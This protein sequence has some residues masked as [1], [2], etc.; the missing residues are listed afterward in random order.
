MTKHKCEYCGKTFSNI[1]SLAK[2]KKTATYCI[3]IQKKQFNLEPRIESYVCEDCSQEFIVKCNY[4]AHL[5][6]C[7]AKK[8]HKYLVE[9]ES[10]QGEVNR[11][12]DINANYTTELSVYKKEVELVKKMCE[13]KDEEIAMLRE[14]MREKEEHIRTHPSVTNIYQTNNNNILYTYE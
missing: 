4:Q 7:K 13:E 9:I 14:L 2:H 3:E 10:L 8:E 1:Y 11:L 12:T 5:L 6:V